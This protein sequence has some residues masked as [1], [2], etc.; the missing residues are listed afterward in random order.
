MRNGKDGSPYPG[1]IMKAAL[2][3]VNTRRMQ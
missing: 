1:I 3:R 2:I